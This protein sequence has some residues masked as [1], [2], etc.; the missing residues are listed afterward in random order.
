MV[1]QNYDP[2]WKVAGG[3]AVEERRGLIAVKIPFHRM[4][5]ALYYQPLDFIV[6][7]VISAAGY[8]GAIRSGKRKQSV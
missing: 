4:S 7:L 8:L 1:N 5:V 2:G 6:G 3:G